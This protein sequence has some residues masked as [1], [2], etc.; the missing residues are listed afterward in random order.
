LSPPHQKLDNFDGLDYG[1]STL[2]TRNINQLPSSLPTPSSSNLA[3]AY[4]YV[5][6]RL[7]PLFGPLRRTLDIGTLPYSLPQYGTLARR[8]IAPSSYQQ[9]AIGT[10]TFRRI[11]LSQN[12]SCI[13]RVYH[14]R[15]AL[16]GSLTPRTYEVI[17]Y[18][19]Q[20]L[21]LYFPR[22]ISSSI[23]LSGSFVP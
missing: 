15:I 3:R 20:A 14:L 1:Y 9:T 18:F 10:V 4:Y 7:E 2:Y 5:Q 19:L 22:Q 13:L 17:P 16:L 6:V 23:T 8:R 11:A 21:S 12:D